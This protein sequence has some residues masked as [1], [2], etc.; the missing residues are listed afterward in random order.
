MVGCAHYPFRSCDPCGFES[1]MG[2]QQKTTG[3]FVRT[4]S[5]LQTQGLQTFL[6]SVFLSSTAHSS[7]ALVCLCYQR[8][9][10]PS[11]VPLS[12]VCVNPLS[13][14][15]GCPQSSSTPIFQLLHYFQSSNKATISVPYLYSEIRTNPWSSALIYKRYSH[16]HLIFLFQLFTYN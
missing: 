16:T 6:W 15:P 2:E 3:I 1:I 12:L 8:T 7:M 14:N 10:H 11:K 9:L 13:V 5:P 4:Q